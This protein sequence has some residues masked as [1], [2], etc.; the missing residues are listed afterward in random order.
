M[1]TGK[2]YA[3]WV[4]CGDGKLKLPENGNPHLVGQF[5]NCTIRYWKKGGS[6][7]W[8]C[9]NE[10]LCFEFNLFMKNAYKE[11]PGEIQNCFKFG[12]NH[13][14]AT[15]MSA[16]DINK[17][18]RQRFNNQRYFELGNLGNKL[19]EG[20]YSIPALGHSLSKIAIGTTISFAQGLDDN[21]QLFKKEDVEPF[22]PFAFDEE[23]AMT[24]LLYISPLNSDFG[25]IV[26]DGGFS[27]LFTELDTEG[28]GKYIQ[29]IIG[30]TSMYHKHLERDGDN[31]MENF[32]LPS[33]EQ[34]IDYNEKFIDNGLINKHKTKEYDIVYMIDATGSMEKWIEAAADKCMKIS[35]DLK[36]KFPYLDF[37]F[38]G[39]FYRDPVDSPK[40]IHEV[41][42]LTNDMEKLK[43]NFSSIKA[44]GGGDNEEDWVGAFEKVLN[45]INWKD[46][47]KLIIHIADAP[48]HTCEFCGRINHEE[49][50]LKM[51]PLLKKCV[52]KN[53]KII[54]FS[55]ND[56]A[57]IS[58]ER[59]EEYYNAYKGFYKIYNFDDAKNYTTISQYFEDMVIEAAVCAAPKRQE[60]Y[61]V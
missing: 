5:I 58:F 18:P 33:F 7:V 52:E 29:N 42:D 50:N 20:K 2:Y 6:L 41:F 22:I 9:D 37:Y 4:I 56:I 19:N 27:K 1:K 57:K 30:F 8:W 34:N 28:T 48:A 12:G 25:N 51:L 3:T 38:G 49:Q 35:L 59:C 31:W 61:E 44:E 24:I 10:P 54:G 16:G 39:I 53:I 26:V 55:I 47:T 43:I 23:G 21:K 40:D 36:S 11:F 60:I 15:L 13:N 14:G 32:R 46:G 17:K 45:S